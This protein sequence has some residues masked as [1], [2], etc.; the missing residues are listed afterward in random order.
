MT[1]ED[2]ERAF[3]FRALTMNAPREVERGPV[4][5]DGEIDA[6]AAALE[7]AVDWHLKTLTDVD[8]L[9]AADKLAEEAG[10]LVDALALPYPYDVSEEAADV[11]ITLAAY[12]KRASITPAKLAAAVDKKLAVLRTRNYRPDGT[13][14]R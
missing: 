3:W 10:E 7:R 14:E 1:S 8:V 2:E 11:A 4:P 5:L 12:C 9:A 6:L 13:R